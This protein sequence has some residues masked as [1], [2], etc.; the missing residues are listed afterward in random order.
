MI[1]SIGC[2]YELGPIFRPILLPALVI[3]GSNFSIN[4]V[5]KVDWSSQLG[6]FSKNCPGS[7][8][9]VSENAACVDIFQWMTEWCL[10]ISPRNFFNA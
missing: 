8:F 3:F 9:D 10:P 1:P 7:I 6:N 4:V 5:R 2:L